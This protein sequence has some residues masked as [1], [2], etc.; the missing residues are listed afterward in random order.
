MNKSYK[1]DNYSTL[2]SWFD[3]NKTNLLRGDVLILTKTNSIK[4]YYYIYDHQK[5]INYKKSIL[6]IAFPEFDQQY[7]RGIWGRI[8]NFDLSKFKI[9]EIS[10]CQERQLL[11]NI[12]TGKSKHDELLEYIILTYQ[13]EDYYII[14]YKY[15]NILRDLIDGRYLQLRRGFIENRRLINHPEVVNNHIFSPLL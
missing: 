1:F 6:K 2:L 7:F 3:Q 13:A 9:S 11:F 4:E 14:S 12:S 10:E 15:L 5:L 8:V